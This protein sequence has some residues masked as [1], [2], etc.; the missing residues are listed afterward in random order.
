MQTKKHS[1]TYLLEKYERHL[2]SVSLIG[3]FIFDNL[4]LRRIDTFIDQ[5]L[6]V[7]YLL[8]AAF[9]IAWLSRFEGRHIRGRWQSRWHTF[10]LIALQFVLGGLFSVF[11]IFYFRSATIAASWPF[12]IFLLG[13]LIGN[14]FLRNRYQ[15][16]FFRASVFFVALYSYL[17]FFIPIAAHRVGDDIFIA[18]GILA[19]GI[20]YFFAK[21]VFALAHD[22]TRAHRTA[23]GLT[24]LALFAL[25][26]V[27]YFFN[28]I[29]PIPL[30]LKDG[31][32]AAALIKEPDG[33]YLIARERAPWYAAFERYPKIHAGPDG[34]LY[35]YSAIFAPTGLD[36]DV[37][38]EWQYLDAKSGDW[39]TSHRVQFAITGG[40][41]R[42]YRGYSLKY[43][44]TP[45][46]WRV[47]IENK[48]GQLIGRVAFEVVSG[49]PSELVYETR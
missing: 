44:I 38:H 8:V 7:L 24:A 3:G 27:F 40:A 10:T 20:F 11:F 12:L 14:E 13:L 23:L 17:I 5:A 18:S 46:L 4:T 34:T 33:S 49:T 22:P 45:G 25:I 48:R 19:L 42:G 41:N 16:A 9:A 36:A 2:S 15:V 1:L 43:N 6:I 32:V 39:Q 31:F 29:P 30:A 21:L 37:V 47:N 28:I 35:V 26:N